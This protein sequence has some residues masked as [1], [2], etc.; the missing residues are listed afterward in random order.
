MDIFQSVVKFPLQVG[1]NIS[2][3][4]NNIVPK[5]IQDYINNQVTF[6]CVREWLRLQ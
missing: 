5:Q 4:E 6:K 2:T 1:P 3:R